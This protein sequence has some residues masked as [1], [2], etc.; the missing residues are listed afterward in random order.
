MFKITCAIY[1]VLLEGT[2]FAPEV[3]DMWQ[4][5]LNLQ[6]WWFYRLAYWIMAAATILEIIKLI[7]LIL[8]RL[9]IIAVLDVVYGKFYIFYLLRIGKSTFSNT[10]CDKP[11]VSGCID[12]L[13]LKR[14]WWQLEQTTINKTTHVYWL[15]ARYLYRTYNVSVNKFLFLKCFICFL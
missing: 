10:A 13:K 12:V 9:I 8:I 15:L 7:L 14:R 3:F 1:D 4:L 2:L 5:S 11:I 6:K